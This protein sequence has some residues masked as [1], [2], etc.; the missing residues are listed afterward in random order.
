MENVKELIK[1][2]GMA[3][4]DMAKVPDDLKKKLQEARNNG[5]A[6]QLKKLSDE[7]QKYQK[8]RTGS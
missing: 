2:S 6:A 4:I 5:D 3:N 1:I 8:Q 7:L